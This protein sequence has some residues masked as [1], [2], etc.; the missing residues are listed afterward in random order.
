MT[1]LVF[2]SNKRHRL[3]WTAGFQSDWNSPRDHHKRHGPV[4]C[5]HGGDAAEELSLGGFPGRRATVESLAGH[6]P[7]KFQAMPSILAISATVAVPKTFL[8]SSSAAVASVD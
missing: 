2:Y 6:N 1:G 4:R 7:G 8:A 5:A 3:P